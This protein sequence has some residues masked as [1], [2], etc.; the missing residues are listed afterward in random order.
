MRIN[1][2]FIYK[3]L[4]IVWLI[5]LW[6]NSPLKAK[7]V[8]G[9]ATLRYSLVLANDTTEKD[10]V[11]APKNKGWLKAVLD[12]NADDSIKV[13][14][15]NNSAYLYKNASISYQNIG[16][17]AG[18]IKI[19]WN[20]NT[21]LATGIL[22]SN[23]KVVEKPIFSENDKIFETDTIVYNFNTQKASIKTLNT[24]EGESYLAGEKVK[25]TSESIYYIKGT[26]FTTCSNRH[27]HFRVRTKKAKVIV[28][29]QIVTGPAYLEFADIPTPLVIPF[30]F[31]PTQDKR[32]SGFVFPTFDFATGNDINPGRG[33]GL[34]GGGY[35]WA[36]SDY[37]DL[38]ITGDIYSKGG[39]G[40]RAESNYVKKYK[41]RGYISARYNRTRIGDP[42]Y[43]A[44]DAFRDSKDFRIDWTHN[45]DPKARPDLRFGAKVNFATFNYN[46]LNTTNPADY[47]QSTMAS[48]IS[49]DKIWL[50]TPFSMTVSANHSQNKQSGNLELSL[51]RVSF[52]MRRIMPFAKKT[53]IGSQSWYEKVGVVYNL[54]TENRFTGN[55]ED[56]DSIQKVVSGLEYGMKQTVG[57]STNEKVLK[58]FSF[59]PSFNYTNRFYPSKLNY[60]FNP[61]SNEVITDTINGFEVVQDFNVSASLSSKVY[62]M[63]T[64]KKGNV[65]AIRHVMTPAVT[66]SF[67][68]DFGADYWG[69][70]QEVQ[71]DTSGTTAR[72]SRY[73]RYLYGS[74]GQGNNGNLGL[75]LLNVLEGKKRTVKDSTK[76]K[77]FKILDQFNLSTSY[78]INQPVFA[79]APLSMRAVT[80]VFKNKLSLT[81]QGLYDF[82]GRDAE[83]VRINRSALEVNNKLFW[84]TNNNF[85]AD[86]TFRGKAERKSEVKKSATGLTEGNKNYFELDNYMDFIFPWSITFRYNYQSRLNMF[87]QDVSTHSLGV[88]FIVDPTPNWH[89]AVTTGYDIIRKEITYTNVNITRDLHCWELTLNWVP[90]GFAQSYNIGIRIKASQFK[91]VKYEQR[92]GI[93]DF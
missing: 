43:E 21:V 86:I 39:W 8:Y 6:T 17:S 16:L 73:S 87:S 90:F 24:R 68:P 31:F 2:G 51:P 79:W 89:L 40:V 82:Y 36:L 3:L 35:Y 37:M 1:K 26:S 66:L 88:N 20:K 14:M 76:E 91:D 65:S 83:G 53:R 32:S 49:L 15:V 34:V 38:K 48:S 67:A 50:G 57:V 29:K 13:N 10:S 30:G 84:N 54:Q 4:T 58:Y 59:S 63:F 74:P 33:F 81:Y 62:G 78:R 80:R 44:F 64:F 23:G 9:F 61:D 7:E 42:R 18:F 70:Y 71:T 46:V 5:I 85:S 47:L 11:E 22:D 93:G 25:R 19:D 41:Y 55:I 69:Y 45:Q 75:S 77:K 27:P 72:F 92:R 12:Y 56:F 60:T 52:N 28:G